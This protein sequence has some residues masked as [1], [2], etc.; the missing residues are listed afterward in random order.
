M[1]H[2]NC[3][4]TFLKRIIKTKI[5]LKTNNHYIGKKKKCNYPLFV[6]FPLSFLLSAPILYFL[7]LTNKK[8]RN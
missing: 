8:Q 7:N 5:V 2:N 3:L 4:D 6:V 1:P